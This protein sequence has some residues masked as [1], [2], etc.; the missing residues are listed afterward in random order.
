M[1]SRRNVLLWSAIA[2]GI[3]GAAFVFAQ[4]AKPQTGQKPKASDAA[5]ATLHRLAGDAKVR[6]VEIEMKDGVEHVEG[7]WR[8]PKSHMEAVVT[9]S[10]D[11]ICVEEAIQADEAPAAAR[12]AAAAEAG[13]D[14]KLKWEHITLHLYEAEFRKDGRERE[15]IY[16][17]DGRRFVEQEENDDHDD[18]KDDHDDDDDDDG[19]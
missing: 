14:V 15:V 3:A 2:T 17:A 10:G 8:G 13:A 18:G 12:A 9:Q 19:E 6:K 7:E 11:I 4:D 16:T 5:M 1:K